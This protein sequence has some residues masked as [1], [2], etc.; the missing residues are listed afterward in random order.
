MCVCLCD[1]NNFHEILS[2][3]YS[4]HI[5]FNDL[6]ICSVS[7]QNRYQRSDSYMMLQ[8]NYKLLFT[9]DSIFYHVMYRLNIL[10]DN[11]DGEST[12]VVN[13]LSKQRTPN[14]TH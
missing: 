10:S 7:N 14:S 12:C 2:L 4:I 13:D 9:Y 8:V 6:I 5:K 3:F 11:K 1:L